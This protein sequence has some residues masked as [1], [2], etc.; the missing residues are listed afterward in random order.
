LAR[1]KILHLLEYYTISRDDDDEYQLLKEK[2]NHLVKND[3][4]IDLT[5]TYDY[6]EREPKPI[7]IEKK[8]KAKTI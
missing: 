7:I 3:Q 8:L 2:Y 1:S 5:L 4:F 6:E